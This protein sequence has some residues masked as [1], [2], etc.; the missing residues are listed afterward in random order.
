MTQRGRVIEIATRAT[1]EAAHSLPKMPSGHKCRRLH[2][3]NYVIEVVC[4]GTLNDKDIVIDYGELDRAVDELIIKSLDHRH[5]NDVYGLESPTGEVIAL[6]CMRRLLTADLP[7]HSVTIWE[8][9]HYRAT[10]YNE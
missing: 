2:G 6:W 4:R 7:V 3:H 9:P 8:T 5:L 10:C 1:F